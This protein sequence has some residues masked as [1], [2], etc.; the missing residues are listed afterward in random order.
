M[1]RYGSVASRCMLW[2]AIGAIVL[3]W[4]GGLAEAKILFDT[5]FEADWRPWNG[6]TLDPGDLKG[7][8]TMKL[9]ASPVRGGKKAISFFCDNCRRSELTSGELRYSWRKEYWVAF[10]INLP[11][12]PTGGN[13]IISQHHGIPAN[14]AGAIDWSCI[15]APN[16]FTMLAFEDRFEVRT[17]TIASNVNKQLSFSG[18]LTGTELIG[19]HPLV[20]NRWYDIVLHFYYAPDASGYFEMWVDKKLLFSRKGPTAYNKVMLPKDG[21]PIPGC[22]LQAYPV[23]YQKIG[24]YLGGKTPAIGEI[25]YDEFRMGDASSSLQEISGAAPI[26]AARCG[27]GII[28]SP[29]TCDPPETCPKSCDDAD[30]CTADSLTGAAANCDARCTHQPITR[31]AGGDGCCPTG[32]TGSEDDDCPPVT[33]DAAADSSADATSDAK[34][35]AASDADPDAPP[36]DSGNS[37][38]ADDLGADQAGTRAD[39][40]RARPRDQGAGVPGRSDATG[41]RTRL[42]S[43][44]ALA[45]G[46]P[47]S[48][49]LIGLALSALLWCRRRRARWRRDDT[50]SGEGVQPR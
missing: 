33:S 49:L 20:V 26:Q 7:L 41:S 37:G 25:V 2:G 38:G 18:A 11:K 34:A 27:N 23:Q 16:L 45:Q 1:S 30:V 5:P 24:I 31:C 21:K 15:G 35:T 47:P 10:S 36:A 12:I 3:G 8:A 4:W 19:K 13:R 6:A 46:P 22:S 28:E 43:G 42:D 32:C 29:E 9:V 17:S 44:C 50:A 39:A 40:G 48:A 14:A